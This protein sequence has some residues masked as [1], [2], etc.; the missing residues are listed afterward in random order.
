M[1]KDSMSLYVIFLIQLLLLSRFRCPVSTNQFQY[2][3]LLLNLVKLTL[4]HPIFPFIPAVPYSFPLPPHLSA[5]ILFHLSIAQIPQAAGQLFVTPFSSLP[6]PQTTFLIP[7]LTNSLGQCIFLP[8]AHPPL[9]IHS[10][11]NPPPHNWWLHL[12]LSWIAE[13]N[14]KCRKHFVICRTI[15][16]LPPPVAVGWLA[17]QVR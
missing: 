7:R 5:N 14:W 15:H 17:V 6:I 10:P 11:P 1:G 16:S 4:K 8:H 9:P 13:I 3:N 2:T 12:P